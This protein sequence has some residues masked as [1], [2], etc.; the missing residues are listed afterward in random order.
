MPK[1]IENKARRIFRAGI[2]VRHEL[3]EV[4]KASNLARFPEAEHPNA[5]YKETIKSL[6]RNNDA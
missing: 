1:F 2:D 3:S 6:P 5:D 4:L